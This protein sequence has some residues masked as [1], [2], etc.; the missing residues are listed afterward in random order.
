MTPF[1]KQ[2]LIRRNLFHASKFTAEKLS[3]I[4]EAYYSKVLR[5]IEG[6]TSGKDK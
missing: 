3:S 5:E 6:E 1:E 4:R 2:E